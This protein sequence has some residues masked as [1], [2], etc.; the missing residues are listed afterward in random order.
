M[1]V[2]DSHKHSSLLGWGIYFEIKGF[3]VRAPY[4]KFATDIPFK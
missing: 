4:K 3:I 1:E 2:T